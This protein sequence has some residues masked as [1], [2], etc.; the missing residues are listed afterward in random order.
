M[1]FI[2]SKDI[3][4][5]LVLVRLNCVTISNICAM[6]KI[7]VA[8]TRVTIDSEFQVDPCCDRLKEYRHIATRYE[9]VRKTIWPW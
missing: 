8:K 3:L 9:T 4:L 5:I 1:I 7:S 2:R 6:Y